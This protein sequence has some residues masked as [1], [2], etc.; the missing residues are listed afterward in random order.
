MFV[1]GGWKVS[2]VNGSR[3]GSISTSLQTCVRRSAVRSRTLLCRNVTKPL[4]YRRAWVTSNG[5]PQ[6][7]RDGSRNC[8]H[9]YRILRHPRT[10]FLS[11]TW[12]VQQG[13]AVNHANA[14]VC[15]LMTL[16]KFCC[17]VICK[18]ISCS[19]RS[20]F[21]RFPFDISFLVSFSFC[22]SGCCYP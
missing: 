5:L 15:W 9:P 7:H 13:S 18:R 3:A 22:G 2:P 12:T 21:S 16:R 17:S 1:V 10:P 11:A 20:A 14:P 6:A 8:G 19:W 4:I